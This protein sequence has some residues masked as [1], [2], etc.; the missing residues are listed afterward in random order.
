MKGLKIARKIGVY[1]TTALV[2]ILT[3]ATAVFQIGGAIAYENAPLI[4]EALGQD[5]SS[6]IEIDQGAD[7]KDTQ[8]YKTKFKTVEEVR[9]SGV[10]FTTRIMEE[11]AVLLKNENNALPLTGDATNMSLFGY[12]SAQPVLLGGLESEQKGPNIK[13]NLRQGLEAEGKITVNDGLYKWYE[14]NKGTYKRK[15]KNAGSEDGLGIYM[16][17]E[18][19]EAPWNV[20]PSNVKTD[21][22]YK[23]AM[24]VIGRIGSEGGDIPIHLVGNE[25]MDPGNSTDENLLRLTPQEKDMIDNLKAEKAKGTFDRIIVLLNTTNQVQLDFLDGIDAAIWCGGIG[26]AGALGI[27]RIL[28]GDVNPSGR[29]SDTFWKDHSKNPVHANY[30]QMGFK[31]FGGYA[32][33]TTFTYDNTGNYDDGYYVYQ[34]GIYVGYRYTETRYE[35][36]VLGRANAGNYVYEDVVA[37]PFSHGLSYTTF[38]YEMSDV[39]HN[40][41][42]DIFTVDVKVTNTGDVAGKEAVHLFLQKPY[43]QYDIDNRVEKASVELVKYGKTQLLQPGQS[44]TVTLTVEGRE[45]ASYDAY[46]AKTYVFEQGDYYFS[47][48]RDAHEAVNNILRSKGADSSKITSIGGG[49]TGDALLCR[50]HVVT[51]D[52]LLKYSVS[53]T[54]GNPITNQF[55]NA[56]LT[57]DYWKGDAN[58]KSFEYVSRSDW[59]RTAKFFK[60]DAN[61]N[62]DN[63]AK[64]TRTPKITTESAPMWGVEPDDGEY[65]TME[66]KKTGHQLIDLM[67]DEF[68]EPRPYDD[69]MWE[70]LLDQLSWKEMT[71]VLNNGYFGTKAIASIGAPA[72]K[73]QDS[74]T[75][76]IAT[77]LNWNKKPAL[78]CNN[79]IVAATRNLPLIE[80]YGEQWGEDCYW[81]GIQFLYGT[82]GNMHRSP[83]SGRNYGYYSEDPV[84]C[85]YTAAYV[86]KGMQSM[87]AQ[88]FMKHCFLNDQE[89]NRCGASSWANEQTCR[90][91]YLKTYQI[92]IEVGNIQG[93]MTALNRIGPVAAPH[94]PFM[95][96]VLRDEFGMHGCNI[97]DSMMPFNTNPTMTL[98]GLDL[99]LGGSEISDKYKEGYANVAWAMRRNIHNVLYATAHSS[100]MNGLSSNRRIVSF[101]PAWQVYLAHYAELVELLWFISLGLF[102]AGEVFYWSVELV[103]LIAK[104]KKEAN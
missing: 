25:G 26:D 91:I 104:R 4:T 19:C 83:Y 27:S 48:G 81:A 58:Y 99:P 98:N 96:T 36:V 63:S 10:N 50:K 56:D 64:L 37:Y 66:S 54:T 59:N 60:L 16:I 76:C 86:N 65:P 45:L 87:G 22:N 1:A 82:G 78:N 35:D 15:N 14:N 55:D 34:E 3:F 23:T 52:N 75:G 47:V 62:I 94:H 101:E 44:E 43:T 38:S 89:V 97:T 57:S 9:E 102:A 80:E 79:D 5:Y 39:H 24:Y 29:L 41:E 30:G 93:V 92:G 90:E 69:P 74:D 12:T 42:T 13:Y 53:K 8:Y 20:I 32:F 18:Y 67:Y 21:S 95:N 61:G 46:N 68:G 70:E 71:S 84:I 6:I 28:T 85:G 100:A 33:S 2:S 17:T 49:S 51:E 88:M 11:G 77:Y 103:D 73:H 40:T 31:K 72:T 7:A